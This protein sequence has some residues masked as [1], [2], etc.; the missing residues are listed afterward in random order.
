MLNFLIPDRSVL[1]LDAEDYHDQEI[2]LQMVTTPP[3]AFCPHCRSVSIRVCS[4]CHR[5]IAGLPAGGCQGKVRL[6][7]RR[8]FCDQAS[9]TKRT[10]TERI[11]TVVAHY[12]RKATRLVLTQSWVGFVVGGEAG[13]RVS[14]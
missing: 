1:H 3:A 13:V 5:T 8:F 2:V 12:G 9:C 11:P 7:I 4:A 6:S 14:W 10:F